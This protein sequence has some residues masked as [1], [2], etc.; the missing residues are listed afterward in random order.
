MT[1]K[2]NWWGRTLTNF[3]HFKEEIG[4]WRIMMRPHIEKF[5]RAEGIADKTHEGMNLIKESFALL[6]YTLSHI[7]ITGVILTG[8]AATGYLVYISYFA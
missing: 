5:S 8:L 3:D 4:L 6:P 1:R 7:W 2:N